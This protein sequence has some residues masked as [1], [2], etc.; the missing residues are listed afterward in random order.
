[1]TTSSEQTSPDRA[2]RLEVYLDDETDPIAE[3]R[4][5]A[6]ID[7]DT[8]M[9]DDGEH[10]L[11]V[12]VVDENGE[13]ASVRTIPFEVRNGPAIAVDGLEAGDV[14]DGRVSLMVHAWGGSEEADWEPSRAESPAPA[15][16]W[17]WVLLIAIISWAMYYAVSFWYPTGDYADSPT[18]SPPAVQQ[19]K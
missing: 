3:Y 13:T 17:A 18:Y 8:S 7:L 14:V 10:R 15:P 2:E 11:R 19:K 16:T 5:P 1:M 9:L 12:E 4:A 6:D